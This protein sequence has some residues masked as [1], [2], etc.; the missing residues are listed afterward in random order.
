MKIVRRDIL[1]EFMKQHPE[2][3]S[4]VDVC[5]GLIEVAEW[6]TPHD[7]TNTI[8][9]A[10]ILKERRII[11]DVKGNEYRLEIE[12]SYGAGVVSVV[13]IGTHKEYDERNETR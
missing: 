1:A 8:T 13:W 2:A 9:K 6:K 3:K 12:V 5:V 4:S 7:V 10:S 11:L